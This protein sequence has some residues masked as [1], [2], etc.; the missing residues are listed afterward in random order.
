MQSLYCLVT[1]MLGEAQQ[2]TTQL[3]QSRELLRAAWELEKNGVPNRE[4][5]V[6]TLEAAFNLA[7]GTIPAQRGV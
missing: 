3:S 6:G 4:F 7:Q 2:K 5:G 1:N